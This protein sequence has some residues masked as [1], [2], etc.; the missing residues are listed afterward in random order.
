MRLS[1]PLALLLLAGCSSVR[2]PR[3]AVDSARVE[4]GPD[5]GSTVVV[6]LDADNRNAKP[7]PLRDISYEVWIGGQRVA[8]A[9]RSSQVTLPAFGR[10]R[11]ELPFGVASGVPTGAY[12]VK[13]RVQY[14]PPG[15]VNESLADTGLVKPAAG[16]SGRGTLGE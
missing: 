8:R 14:I 11:I 15:A 13:G 16:F 1:L 3:L 4:P 7:L 9:T 2:P 6:V 5:G 12:R 10:Q